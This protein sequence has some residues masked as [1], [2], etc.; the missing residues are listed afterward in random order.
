MVRTAPRRASLTCRLNRRARALRLSTM[1]ILRPRILT[2]MVSPRARLS[3]LSMVRAP[4]C[5]SA[6]RIGG[7]HSSRAFAGARA[8]ALG[9]PA[10]Y[11]RQHPS[12]ALV[13][14]YESADFRRY[15]GPETGAVEYAI[16]ADAGLEMM[17]AQSVGKVGA[18][19]LCSK[20]LA[21]PGNVV[22]LALH[23]HERHFLD[24]AR[25]DEA[26]AVDHLALGK[27][28]LEEDRFDGLQIIFRR[29]V[30]NSKELVVE[31]AMLVG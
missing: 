30:H 15:F 9:S 5:R 22:L 19:N 20:R 29:E 14:G 16:M 24:L 31:L 18:Q 28:V 7:Q 26:V 12:T 3:R 2:S 4:Y 21:D 11:P 17:H 13:C 8:S 27:P 6:P 1:G 25:I 10:E 23:R